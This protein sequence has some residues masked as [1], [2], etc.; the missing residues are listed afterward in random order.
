VAAAASLTVALP[1][2]AGAA[3]PDDGVLVPGRTLGGVALGAGRAGVVAAWGPAY[4]RC[5]GCRAETLYFNRFAFRPE[6]AA[7]ELRDGR[8]V[9]VFTLWA[10]PGWRT[11][12]G[13]RIGEPA[14]RLQA[15][16]R[17]L[18]RTRCPGYDAYALPGSGARSVVYVV[19]GEVWGFALLERGRSVCL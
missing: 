13:L 4:G 7:V 3:P 15:T 18:R 10:P 19:D 8:V 11:S 2:T 6:G 5:R 12:A 1:G 9:A 16:Y 17:P 14:L